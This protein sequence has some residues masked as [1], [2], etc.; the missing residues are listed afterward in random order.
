MLGRKITDREARIIRAEREEEEK[1][2]DEEEK[3]RKNAFYIRLYSRRY[4]N[5]INI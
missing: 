1:R 4:E 2:K 3:K 5:L